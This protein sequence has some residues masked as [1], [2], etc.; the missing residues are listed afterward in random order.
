[1]SARIWRARSAT[2]ANQNRVVRLLRSLG[3]TWQRSLQLRVAT[4]TLLI[5]GVT[6]VIIGIF[7][8]DQVASGI[9]NAKRD[10]AVK[11]AQLGAPVAS[12]QLA[13][14]SAG[15]KAD[16]DEARD[17][18]TAALTGN[19]QTGLYSIVIESADGPRADRIT[20]SGVP[21]ALRKPVLAGDSAYQYAPVPAATA[22]SP[23]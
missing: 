18:I 15:V 9:L 19:G 12:E 8:V 13:I 4:T 1:M 5:T 14:V 11:Q 7:I 21:E 22:R 2:A 10:A 6:V 3:L 20:E 17:N 23:G 16:V